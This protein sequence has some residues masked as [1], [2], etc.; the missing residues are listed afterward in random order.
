M[1]VQDLADMIA[2]P[3][4]PPPL[5]SDNPHQ[6]VDL[7]Q[8]QD[9]MA[10]MGLP[11]QAVLPGRVA[12]VLSGRFPY[13][14]AVLVETRLDELPADWVAALDLPAVPATPESFWRPVRSEASFG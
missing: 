10:L 6:G 4:N 8:V 1:A 5:G 12:L 13:G 3:Y 7:A 14:N 9:G 2:N 11:V